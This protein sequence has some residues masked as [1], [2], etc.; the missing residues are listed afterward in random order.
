MGHLF[1]KVFLSRLGLLINDVTLAI[2]RAEWKI[3]DCID[4]FTISVIVGINDLVS[5]LSSH[6]GR[7]SRT[8][9]LLGDFSTILCPSSVEIFF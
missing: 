1:L 9:D 4:F 7:W 3:V 8:E 5:F 6:V 2:L